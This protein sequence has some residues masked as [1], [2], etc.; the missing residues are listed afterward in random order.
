MSACAVLENA[1][2]SRYG[3]VW[4]PSCGAIRERGCEIEPLPLCGCGQWTEPLLCDAKDCEE[5]A[6][7]QRDLF[8][9]REHA[10]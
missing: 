1:V 4:C 7:I 8:F 6:T 10:V 3:F 9:C 2:V 5:E